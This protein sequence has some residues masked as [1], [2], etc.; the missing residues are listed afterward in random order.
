M[1]GGAKEAT[2]FLNEAVDLMH[3][4]RMDDETFEIPFISL[5]QLFAIFGSLLL[6]LIVPL[7]KNT[8]NEVKRYKEKTKAKQLTL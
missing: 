4:I 1:G 7:I 3:K 5:D 6:P 8:V 2:V